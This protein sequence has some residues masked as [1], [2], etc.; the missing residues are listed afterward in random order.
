MKEFREF[1]TSEG[2][3]VLGGKN[4]E[5]NEK[6]IAQVKENE[7]VLHTK[8]AGSPFC[9]IKEEYR[10]T[11]K[12]D[13]KEAAIFCAAYSRDWKKNKKDVLVHYFLGKDI[14]KEKNMNLGTFGVRRFKEILVKKEEI[15]NFL[16]KNKNSQA[17]I[18]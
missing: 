3:L 12:K 9:N 13:I 15:E 1:I 16:K 5:S 14:F 18:I 6:L 2:K 17:S 4:A 7:I 11:N 10:K 8:E